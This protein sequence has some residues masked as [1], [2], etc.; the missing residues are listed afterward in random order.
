[1]RRNEMSAFRNYIQPGLF[2]N[3]KACDYM[4]FFHLYQ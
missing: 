1:V 2:I 4:T 3:Q